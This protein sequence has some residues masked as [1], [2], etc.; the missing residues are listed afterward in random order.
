MDNFFGILYELLVAGYAFVCL[1]FDDEFFFSIRFI[2][3][4]HFVLYWHWQAN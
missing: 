4:F 1:S 3:F 2:E